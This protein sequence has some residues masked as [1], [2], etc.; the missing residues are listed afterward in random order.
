MKKLFI[1]CAILI[2]AMS[3]GQSIDPAR[4]IVIIN[5]DEVKANEYY[6]RMEFLPGVGRQMGANMAIFPP[7]FL[8]IEQIVTERLVFQ[9]AKSKG[10]YPTDAEVAA[11]LKTA[12]DDYPQLLTQWQ[13]SGRTQGEL[14][15]QFRY[16]LAQFKLQTRGVTITDQEV[17]QHYKSNP[18][19]FTVP[20]RV[21]LRAI[22]V[23]P[24]D[25]DS[26]DADLK[27]GKKFED[28]AKARSLDLTSSLGGAM[29][30]VPL[31]TLPEGARQVIEATKTG[32]TT[33][34]I[35]LQQASVKYLV[36]GFIA[37]VLTPLDDK[38]RRQIRRDMMGAR[39]IGKNDVAKE[40]ATL[41]S[42]AKIDIKQKEFADA[43]KRFIDTFLTEKGLAP[44]GG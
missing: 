11:E 39:S 20:K 1:G 19:I 7:G 18:T 37:P 38:L 42:T 40:L 24:A 22:A 36:E 4:T 8:T 31:G 21:T 32:Q 41:R 44:G 12:I 26:I 25:K 15:Y 27:A 35:D 29:G 34:W 2:A 23:A 5:C 33:P 3:M 16:N 30:S 28:V 9:L 17:D 13:A 14:E 43:Y 6:R 10:V